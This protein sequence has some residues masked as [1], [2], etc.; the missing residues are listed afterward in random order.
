MEERGF[1]PWDHAC[2]LDPSLAEFPEEEAE[3]EEEEEREAELHMAADQPLRIH[4]GARSS[5]K[6]GPNFGLRPAIQ[7]E[8][9]DRL[10]GDCQVPLDEDRFQ[11]RLESDNTYVVTLIPQVDESPQVDGHLESDNAYVLTLITPS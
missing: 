6:F 1:I 7:A 11:G 10:P 3:L 8:D 5:P 4:F 9:E 2:E